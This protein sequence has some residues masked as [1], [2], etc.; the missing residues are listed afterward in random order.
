LNGNQIQ[1]WW[2][3][4]SPEECMDKKETN[5]QTWGVRSQG[6]RTQNSE[7]RSKLGGEREGEIL[8]VKLI[9]W[10]NGKKKGEKKAA[11]YDDACH[12]TPSKSGSFVL[13]SILRYS[14]LLALA[15]KAR[16]LCWGSL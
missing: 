14:Y 3:G 11:I 15:T 2:V 7:L 4:T 13:Y 6:L 5:H 10:T 1:H 16:I 9:D 12:K 8:I